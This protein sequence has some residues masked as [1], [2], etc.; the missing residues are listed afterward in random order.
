MNIEDI[1]KELHLS[2]EIIA[3]N[4]G[5]W[6]PLC[7]AA[8]VAIKEGYSSEASSRGDDPDTMRDK[9]SGL[10][11]YSEVV[12]DAKGVLSRFLGSSPDEVALC[13]S[14][15]TGMNIFLWG[16]DWKPSDEIIAGSLENPAAKVPLMILAKRRGV[17]LTYINQFDGTL[18]QLSEKISD[19]TRMVL[20][21][22]VNF[23]TGSRVGLKEASRIAHDHGAL[24]LA[25]GIQAVGTSFVDVKEL[26]MD[27]YALARHKFMCGPDGAGALYVSKDAMEVI[28]PTYSGVFSDA[29]H[30]SGELT[31]PDSAQRYEVST[32]PLPVIQSGT[33]ATEWIM[34]KVSLPFIVKITTELY[35]A[36]WDGLNDIFKVELVSAKD[37][38]SLLSFRVKGVEPKQVVDEFRKHYIFTRTVGALDPPVVR[39]AVGF[40]N[41]PS[42]IEKIVEVVKGL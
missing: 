3:L 28:E 6:G 25:D 12:A 37:Q 22:D 9:G 5:S 13:D 35:E 19:K 23:A 8:R 14:T 30:G 29:H 16:Y 41:R 33:A 39:V 18:E 4:A 1:R 24:L 38:N 11:R 27:G 42:D 36:L 15:T 20:L 40:W 2:D 7:Q 31:Y 32:R 26:D 34:D 17:K 21:S 10:A